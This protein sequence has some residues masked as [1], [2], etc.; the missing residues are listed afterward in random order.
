MT[1]SGRKSILFL[2]FFSMIVNGRQPDPK[3]EIPDSLFEQKIMLDDGIAAVFRTPLG[4]GKVPAVLMLHGFA[5][6]KNEVGDAY[7][8]LAVQL[9][10]KNIA[11]LRIDFRGWGESNGEMESSTIPGQIED[12]RT[13]Y[14]FLATRPFID[15][16]RIGVI[17]FSLGGGIAIALS[18]H[19]QIR[20]MVLWSSIAD[21][22]EDVR[23]NF[24]AA[25]RETAVKSGMVDIDLG[26]RKIV[27]GKDFFTRLEERKLSDDLQ[28]FDGNLLVIAGAEDP[29][30]SH[31]EAF[32]SW[33][34]NTSARK[35]I[36]IPA[37]GHIFDALEKESPRLQE[38]IGETIEWFKMSLSQ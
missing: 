38:V 20:T 15:S 17:G 16:T 32:E 8:K 19:D 4:W 35:F 36:L 7:K 9:S 3:S 14:R 13:A 11:S 1:R 26:W 34:E 6:Q 37:S 22:D 27:L 25:I 31:L 5:S 24:D 30:A 10:R 18:E 21:F 28:Q 23:Q 29:L 12:A 2:L 33:S